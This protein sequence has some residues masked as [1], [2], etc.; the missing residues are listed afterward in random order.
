MKWF[1]VLKCELSLRGAQINSVLRDFDSPPLSRS[2]MKPT[3]VA[4]GMVF[5]KA[6]QPEVSTTVSSELVLPELGGLNLGTVS[7]PARYP[8]D[9]VLNAHSFPT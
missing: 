9:S 2:S 5:F 3:S 8:R 4:L 1:T 7:S 6:L